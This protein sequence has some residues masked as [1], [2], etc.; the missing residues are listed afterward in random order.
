MHV[1]V[2][3]S[4]PPLPFSFKKKREQVE[5]ARLI[6]RG[7]LIGKPQQQPHYYHY[8]KSHIAASS[9]SLNT[10]IYIYIYVCVCFIKEWVGDVERLNIRELSNPLFFLE[11]KGWVSGFLRIIHPGNFTSPQIRAGET[12][13]DKEKNS[14]MRRSKHKGV[15]VD[16]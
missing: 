15:Y 12:D 3:C 5:V 2:D 9:S 6:L 13:A 10:L 1:C 8:Q 16:R 14:I 7:Y 11:G 4:T